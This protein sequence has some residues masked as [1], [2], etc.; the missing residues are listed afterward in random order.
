MTHNMSW[1]WSP[2]SSEDRYSFHLEGLWVGKLVVLWPGPPRHSLKAIPVF[3]GVIVR[4][5]L[6]Y[7]YK[8]EQSG[9][10]ALFCTRRHVLEL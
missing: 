5:S 6:W 10:K 8:M 7:V 1:T 3:T 9:L 4:F 2:I